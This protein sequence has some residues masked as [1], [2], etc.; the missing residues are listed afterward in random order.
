P[1]QPGPAEAACRRLGGVVRGLVWDPIQRAAGGARELIL[2]PEGVVTEVPWLAVPDAAGRYLADSPFT[3]RQLGAER[4]LLAAPPAVTGH[5][6]LA[7][8][9]P[10]FGHSDAS[11]NVLAA[12]TPRA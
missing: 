4:D 2:V 1:V 9:G 10:D 7:V 11:P 6:L 8:G 12:A 5:G 3:V